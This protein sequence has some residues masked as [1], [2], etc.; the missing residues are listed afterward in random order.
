VE[1]AASVMANVECITRK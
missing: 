1:Q